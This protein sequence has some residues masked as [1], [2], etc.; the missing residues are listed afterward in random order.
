MF[1]DR[2]PIWPQGKKKV[3]E[4]YPWRVNAE[5][6]AVLDEADFVPA[7]SM[8]GKIE[9][10]AKWP[11]EHWP[12]A[13]QGQLRTI[14]P[15]D[16]ELGGADRGGLRITGAHSGASSSACRASPATIRRG[17]AAVPRW[18]RL[19]ALVEDDDPRQRED[20]RDI[21]DHGARPRRPRS[22]GGRR[23]RT[24][25]RYRGG[26]DDDRGDRRR[27]RVDAAGPRRPAGRGAIRRRE[28]PA[29]APA[30]VE[31]GQ[32]PPEHHR[33]CRVTDS[34]DQDRHRAGGSSKLPARSTPTRATTPGSR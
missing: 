12:L 23:R 14:S 25:G 16:S 30:G 24:R 22:R 11:V 26:Q 9:H 6:V 4:D 2:K 1:E 29:I 21:G 3:H 17:S 8:L 33:A 13:F 5:P 10:L 20:R 34:R 7:E 32:I 15:A 31:V 27:R 19:P 28:C 18:R